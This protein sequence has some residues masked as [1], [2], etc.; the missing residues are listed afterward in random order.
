MADRRKLTR[1]INTFA[2]QRGV[3]IVKY[4]PNIHDDLLG[5]LET[6]C[7]GFVS[8]EKINEILNVYRNRS[9]MALIGDAELVPRTKLEIYLATVIKDGE[10]LVV[11]IIAWAKY[12]KFDFLYG[13]L[14]VMKRAALALSVQ[15]IQA[16]F[17]YTKAALRRLRRGQLEDL[18]F[19]NDDNPEFDGIDDTN[20]L[21]DLLMI[22]INPDSDKS[23]IGRLLFAYFMQ[24]STKVY[25]NILVHLSLQ[26]GVY[27]E[28]MKTLAE[29]FGFQETDATFTREDLKLD[30]IEFK[31]VRAEVET[32][33]ARDD[34]EIDLDD[35]KDILDLSLHPIGNF[36]CSRNTHGFTYATNGSRYVNAAE[37]DTKCGANKGYSNPY[38][39]NYSI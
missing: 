1:H 2:N 17:G 20:N 9:G 22:C 27:N 31:G 23:G 15:G 4:N 34:S 25:D 13:D 28:R 18:L 7:G 37:W 24:R 29:T 8:I 12:H 21:G 10:L 39:G 11:G 36:T 38:A 33:L 6:W 19:E 26:N 3:K 30:S 35:L 16:E 5:D 14:A 32:F